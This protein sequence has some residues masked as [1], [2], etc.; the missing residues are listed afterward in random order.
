MNYM[1]PNYG[2][3]TARAIVTFGSLL[4]YVYN[5]QIINYNA[6]WR[7]IN[8]MFLVFFSFY[9]IRSWYHYRHDVV[10]ANLFDEYCQLRADEIVEEKSKLLNTEEVKR[11]V[12]FNQDLT[13]VLDRVH[14]QSY[15]NSAAD[16]KD[17]ELILQDFIRRYTDETQALP[18]NHAGARIG[19]L[20]GF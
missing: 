9:A 2:K 20:L 19:P 4:L 5:Y 15:T 14:R 18:L 10:R 13:E 11:W 16:F 3:W 12:W 8:K 1:F 7:T 6:H 17:S